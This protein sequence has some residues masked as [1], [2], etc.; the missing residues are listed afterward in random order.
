MARTTTIDRVLVMSLVLVIWLSP[1]VLP[2]VIGAIGV[3]YTKGALFVY[4]FAYLATIGA[5]CQVADH[6]LRR[7]EGHP[8]MQMVRTLPRTH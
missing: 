2:K 1:L 5:T 8:Q 6:F 3:P 4:Y 7:R